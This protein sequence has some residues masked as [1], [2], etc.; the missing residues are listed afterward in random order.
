M[1]EAQESLDI[2]L[3]DPYMAQVTLCGVFTMYRKVEEPKEEPAPESTSAPAD[4]ETAEGSNN[5]EAASI[6][7]AGPEMSDSA[8]PAEG[9]TEA[10]AAPA[11]E[12][13]LDPVDS[14]VPATIEG[15]GD[16]SSPPKTDDGTK[17]ENE[18]K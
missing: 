8:T 15:A 10:E 5:S 1:K 9:T 16:D 12:P 13:P 2:A 3:R 11:T 6:E 4:T 7:S 17:P 18:E 14:A